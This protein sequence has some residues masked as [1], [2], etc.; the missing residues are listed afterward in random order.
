LQSTYLVSKAEKMFLPIPDFNRDS[1]KWERSD[2][3]GRYHLTRAAMR[4]L[5]SAI[6]TERKE[7][8]EVARA[9]LTGL[10]GLFGVLIGLLAV[11][12]GRR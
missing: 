12:L 9:W 3:S 10:T 6:R 5:V 11:I 4:E 7:S 1:E 8:S 2:I